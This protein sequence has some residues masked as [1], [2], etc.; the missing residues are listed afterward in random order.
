MCKVTVCPRAEQVG[1][2]A[3]LLYYIYYIFW[4]TSIQFKLGISGGLPVAWDAQLVVHEH[5]HLLGVAAV[6]LLVDVI[7]G[8]KPADGAG[9]GSASPHHLRVR[10]ENHRQELRTPGSRNITDGNWGHGAVRD[11][12]DGDSEHGV[13]WTLGYQ[14]K[15]T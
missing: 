9:L 11:T 2:A 12:T 7:D 13:I 3:I 5:E 10:P 14:P 15:G 1:L 4:H 8:G 6:V